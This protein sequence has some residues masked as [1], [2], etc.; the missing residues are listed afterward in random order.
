MTPS[1]SRALVVG[2]AIVIAWNLPFAWYWRMPGSFATL[3]AIHSLR[4]AL[5]GIRNVV[6]E[7]PKR[8][9]VV[10][11]VHVVNERAAR[12]AFVDVFF[13]SAEH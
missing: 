7:I 8:H 5:L 1:P 9:E 10:L 2:I 11:V 13:M 6:R 4:K 12:R 3:M